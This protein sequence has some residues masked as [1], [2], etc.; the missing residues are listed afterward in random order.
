M[1]TQQAY[2][3]FIH[4]PI[5]SFLLSVGLHFTLFSLLLGMHVFEGLGLSIFKNRTEIKE[6]Y[7]SFIQVD[8][9]A[10]PDQLVNEKP[11]VDMSQPI[12]EKPVPVAPPQPETKTVPEDVIA[13]T[14]AKLE[15]EN[16]NKK[17]REEEQSKALRQ[18]KEEA[19]REQALKDLLAN[20]GKTGRKK[21]SGNRISQGTS[22]VGMIGSASDQYRAQVGEAI[23]QHFNIYRWQQKKGNLVADIYLEI[24]PT[25]RIKTRKIVKASSDS[26]Y[27]SAVLQAI[28][29][30]QPFPVPQDLSLL[31]EGFQITFKP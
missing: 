13:D 16:K 14:K 24:Y 27:D 11:I 3:N 29:E 4:V 8:V 6:P 25:G 5:S 15:V 19:K 9:V 7:Q 17:L 30:A 2:R 23:R 1:A 20:N 18:L 26:T 22:L 10:L 21:I 31:N 12:V 28:D